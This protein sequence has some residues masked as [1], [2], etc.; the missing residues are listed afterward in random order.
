MIKARLSDSSAS[1]FLQ[2]EKRSSH[3]LSAFQFKYFAVC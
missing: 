3:I 1:R 2:S